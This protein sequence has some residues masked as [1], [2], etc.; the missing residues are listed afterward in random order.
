MMLGAGYIVQ[1]MTEAPARERRLEFGFTPWELGVPFEEVSFPA[2]DGAT[3]RGWLLTRPESR[4]AIVG[5]SGYRGRRSNLLGVGSALWRAGY[6]VLL[7]DYRGHGES[8][9]QR[10]TLGY[11]ETRDFLA[12]LRWLRARLPAAWIGALGYS[13]GGT[14]ALLGAAADAAVRAVV[15][16][17]A[18]CRQEELIRAEWRRRVRLPS[19]PI[20]ELAERLIQRSFGFSYRDVDTLA[21]VGQIA[22][23]P[24]LL[25]HA[26]ADTVVPVQDAYRLHEAAGAGA[27]R[28]I[29]PE[30]SHCCAY[31][32]D[33]E[34]Y[35]A[36]VIEFFDRAAERDAG[37][38]SGV[39]RVGDEDAGDEAAAGG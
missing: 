34:A 22:P 37:L 39:A 15:T 4:R 33:R 35:C 14:V 17:C 12:A 6:N 20:V 29:V 10:V 2:D 18:F 19:T 11:A 13:M 24:L 5:L 38:V 23:R 36:R 27:E 30:A 8:D 7:F 16:D 26:E 28:W 9:G 3:L 21:V 32:L 31:F 25:I 1:Q